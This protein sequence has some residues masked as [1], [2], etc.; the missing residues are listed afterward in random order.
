MLHTYVYVYVYMYML[1]V[2]VELVHFSKQTFK[3]TFMQQKKHFIS[4]TFHETW[5]KDG[6]DGLHSNNRHKKNK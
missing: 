3:V 1:Y 6:Q 5:M 4:K 2:W